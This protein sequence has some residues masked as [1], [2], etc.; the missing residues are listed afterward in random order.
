MKKIKMKL[1]VSS[2][3]DLF[4]LIEGQLYHFNSAERVKN[5]V[6]YFFIL[7]GCAVLA[8]L[9][10]VLHF[11]LVPGLIIA[12]FVTAYLKWKTTTQISIEKVNCPKCST[13]IPSQNLLLKNNETFSRSRCPQ[14][15]ENLFLEI[16]D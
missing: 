3:A 16:M 7:L 8:V 14:C 10:P 12:A 5:A 11:I 13:L 15:Q 1:V 6:K 2:N 4:S 9:I